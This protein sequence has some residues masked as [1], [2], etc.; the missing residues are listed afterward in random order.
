MKFNEAERDAL[1]ARLDERTR[2]LQ[3]EIEELKEQ[4]ANYVLVSDH[5]PI[6][7][8]VWAVGLA[9]ITAIVTGLVAIVGKLVR[10]LG[11]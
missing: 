3:R 6:A 9:V 10:A 4:L 11:L 7:R 1:L 8:I 2:H 5:K